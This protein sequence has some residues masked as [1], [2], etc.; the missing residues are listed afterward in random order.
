MNRAVT[1]ILFGCWLFAASAQDVKEPE[2]PDVF[3]ALSGGQLLKLER[4]EA[5]SR[6]KVGALMTAKAALEI[7]GEASPVRLKSGIVELVV[8]SP[9]SL[10][11]DPGAL[12]HIRK[13]ESKKK[14]REVI[15]GTASPFGAKSSTQSVVA[16]DYSKYGESSIKLSVAALP[17]GEYAVGRQHG[18]VVFCFGVD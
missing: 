1:A 18:Q 5:T 11:S 3:Y 13:M 6:A 17:P 10:K 12:Y 4:Q 15:L 16:F 9:D 2:F 7:P 14:S 8:R